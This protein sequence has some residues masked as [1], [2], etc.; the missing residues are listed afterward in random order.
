MAAASTSENPLKQYYQLVV[1][2]SGETSV[3][4][5][6][7]T[8]VE[9]IGYSNVPQFCRS[10]DEKVAAP[11]GVVFTQMSGDNPWHHCPT[12]QI[13]VCL[14]GTWFVRT[15][16]GVTTELKQGDVLFQDNTPEHLAAK[17]GTHQAMH[18]SGV[19]GATCDQ[20]IVQLSQPRG[21]VPDSKSAPGPL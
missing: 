3:V 10:L 21:P 5:R 19:V 8:N 7:F 14:R 9:A 2:T 13:V 1:D 20:M 17:P 16:D 18:F 4:T 11:T 6:D 15:T 12:A